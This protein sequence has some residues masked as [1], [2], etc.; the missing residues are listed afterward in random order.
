MKIRRWG[1]LLIM[2][3]GLLLCLSA[4]QSK[5]ASIPVQ[6]AYSV[7]KDS[8]V[9]LTLIAVG[10]NLIHGPIYRQAMSAVTIAD[11]IFGQPINKLPLI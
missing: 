3:A 10:D 8:H 9:N 11:L 1:T 2:L 5:T 6:S 4:C 7:N